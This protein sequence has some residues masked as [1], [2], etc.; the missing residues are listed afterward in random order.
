MISVDVEIEI[1]GEKRV[2]KCIIIQLTLVPPVRRRP[3]PPMM[4]LARAS[5]YIKK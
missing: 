2:I 5:V 4:T 1:H 3:I